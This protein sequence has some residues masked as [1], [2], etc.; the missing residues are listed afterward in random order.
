MHIYIKQRNL[1]LALDVLDLGFSSAIE[2]RVYF[3]VLDK[4]IAVDHFLELLSRNEKVVDTVHLA[5]PW[6]SS[7]VANAEAK[8]TLVLLSKFRDKSALSRTTRANHN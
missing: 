4:L 8:L 2:V 5:L 6:L 7:R 1:V 3:A